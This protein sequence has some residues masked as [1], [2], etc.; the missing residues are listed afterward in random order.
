M[1]FYSLCKKQRQ[2][3]R[4]PRAISF[5][6]ELKRLPIQ[7]HPEQKQQDRVATQDVNVLLGSKT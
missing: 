3:S 6:L 2:R 4:C 5:L 7:V 1:F